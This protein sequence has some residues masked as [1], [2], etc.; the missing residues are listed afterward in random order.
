MKTS[1]SI[2]FTLYI[3]DWIQDYTTISQL[4][5]KSILAMYER[6]KTEILPHENSKHRGECTGIP[7]ICRKCKIDEILKSAS[8]IA[9]VIESYKHNG[10]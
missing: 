6:W 5:E 8:S 3:I 9:N 7:M 1:D 4:P 2:A 10:K